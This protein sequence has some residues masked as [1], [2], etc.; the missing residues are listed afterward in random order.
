MISPGWVMAK[1]LA[2]LPPLCKTQCWSRFC[3]FIVSHNARAETFSGHSSYVCV[4]AMQFRTKKQLWCSAS[5]KHHKSIRC[6]LYC[7]S[8][9]GP[10]I[11]VCHVTRVPSAS[12]SRQ[13]FFCCNDTTSD[14]PL[15]SLLVARTSCVLNTTSSK[16]VLKRWALWNSR[17]SPCSCE[18][19]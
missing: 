7:I 3:T 4:I 8:A 18:V 16:C 19:G 1:T 9:C 6:S 11:V 17:L 12:Q 2:N 15:T 14:M 10:T 5:K 13:N